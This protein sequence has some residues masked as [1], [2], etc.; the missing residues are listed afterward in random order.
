MTELLQQAI[1]Q[2]EQLSPHQQD[3]IASWLLTEVQD[4]RQIAQKYDPMLIPKELYELVD[5]EVHR[6]HSLISHRMTWYVTSQSFLMA[7]FAVS[8]SQNHSFKWLSTLFLP[9][10]GILTSLIT[11]GSLIA[12]LVAMSEFKEQ[13]K[14]ILD[15]SLQLQRITPFKDRFLLGKRRWIHVLGMTPPVLIPMIFLFS[16]MIIL[17][18]VRSSLC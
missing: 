1:A 9:I 12:A 6:E 2:I 13:K 7:A 16:W 8:S 4:E 10:L 5:Q 18:F 17:L 3:V 14:H 11:L 15:I